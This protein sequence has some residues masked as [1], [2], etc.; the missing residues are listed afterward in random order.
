MQ[1]PSCCCYQRNVNIHDY[2]YTYIKAGLHHTEKIWGI[3]LC[4]KMFLWVRS[5]LLHPAPP[6]HKIN[7]S[8]GALFNRTS[9]DYSSAS[10][11]ACVEQAT[12]SS[13]CPYTHAGQ[14]NH[15]QTIHHLI[16][17]LQPTPLQIHADSFL[18]LFYLPSSPSKLVAATD[19]PLNATKHL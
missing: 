12:F 15:H 7:W 14:D 3:S 8:L 6:P 1:H 19:W 17:H 2:I 16:T 10:C 4:I 9:L 11:V 5:K 18:P 13:D